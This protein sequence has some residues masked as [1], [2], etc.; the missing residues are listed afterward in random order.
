MFHN[1]DVSNKVLD[2]TALKF[3]TI[4]ANI[5]N[6]DTPG[7]KRQSVSFE[8]TLRQEIQNN[9]IKHIDVENLKPTV[10]TDQATLSYRLDG[11]NVDIDTGMSELAQVKLRYDTLIQ[12][13]NAQIGRYKYI[14]GNIK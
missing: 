6:A 4:A 13:T 9:G 3:N 10:Y 14:L 1:I 2:A 5:T 7:Y 12:R 8:E 11:N